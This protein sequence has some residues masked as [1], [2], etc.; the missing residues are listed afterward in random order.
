MKETKNRRKQRK[1]R[2]G[3]EV[4]RRKMGNEE[5]EKKKTKIKGKT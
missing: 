1:G 3:K 5:R 4:E 2:K